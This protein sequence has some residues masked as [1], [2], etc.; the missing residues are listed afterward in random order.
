MNTKIEFICRIDHGPD[1]A[2]L[3]AGLAHA[4]FE[5]NPQK[6]DFSIL[7]PK[8][9][10]ELKIRLQIQGLIHEDSSGEKFNVY[11][12]LTPDSVDRILNVLINT[13][14]LPATARN[15]EKY[16]SPRINKGR[17]FYDAQRRKGTISIIVDKHT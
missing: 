1:K 5:L 7:L 17:F 12:T 10:A 4:Y 2:R 6:I 11:A 9:E 15:P 8:N 13:G 3:I 16:T 14:L